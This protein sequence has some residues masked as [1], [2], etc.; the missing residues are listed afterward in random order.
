MFSGANAE[1]RFLTAFYALFIFLGIFNSFCARS[2][3]MWFL[4]NISKNKPFIFVM[5]L[6]SLIQIVMIYYGGELFR[7]VPISLRELGTVI[8]LAFSVICFDG[9][10]RVFTKLSGR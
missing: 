3:R 8:F 4:S 9:V 10:R 7:S 6:I 1:A 5:L 2:E